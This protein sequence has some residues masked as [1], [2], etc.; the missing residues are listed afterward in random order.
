MVNL[1]ARGLPSQVKGAG[2]QK[3]C[4]TEEL[5]AELLSRRGSWVQIPPPA[6][7]FGVESA[8]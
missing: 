5:N 1:C 8:H 7:M 6:S 2:A 3:G 4:E